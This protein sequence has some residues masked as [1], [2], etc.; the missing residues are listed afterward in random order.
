MVIQLFKSKKSTPGF[1]YT[2]LLL[3]LFVQLVAL[4][5]CYVFFLKHGYLPAPYVL[6]K[7]DTFMDFFHPLF[8]S[9]H[10][11]RYSE[12]NSVYPSLN[13]ILLKVINRLIGSGE[14]FADAFSLR[15]SE[16]GFE[17][18]LLIIFF[19]LPLTAF[20]SD[21]WN[22]LSKLQRLLIYL[23]FV[24]STPFLFCLERGNLIILTLPLIA[25][26]YS[27]NGLPRAIS[28]AL[29]VNIKPYFL[30]LFLI[31]VF[32]RQ[33]KELIQALT[34]TGLLFFLSG[35]ILLDSEF[36]LIF[37]NLITH[38]KATELFSVPELLSLP[39]SLTVFNRILDSV[40]FHDSHLPISLVFL[41]R[42]VLIINMGSLGLCAGI[43]W[44]ANKRIS[45]NHLF[46]A[47][48]IMLTNINC[49]IGGYSLIFYFALIPIFLRLKY[50]KY[51]LFILCILSLPLDFFI[52]F[53]APISSAYF[54]FL[55]GDHVFVNW[56]VGIGSF[57]RPSA[58]LLLCWLLTFEVWK[59]FSSNY[60]IKHLKTD[61][62]QNGT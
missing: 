47:I 14:Q 8:W 1:S 61:S 5:C 59:D 37:S 18:V 46:A 22:L 56:E 62:L 25:H 21:A 58:N 16:R 10:E 53:K 45:D 42:L 35:I 27:K 31:Y 29:M 17:L 40:I 32:K 7:N 55:L 39:S 43:L 19:T 49:N 51:Y 48:F 6:D 34:I 44:L 60:S 23:I 41:S 9:I 24:T 12:W 4:G 30:F 20:F 2:S 3:I 26:S 11:G 28:I 15:D 36:L 52:L 13:F 38:S 50:S 57:L 54:S 33:W